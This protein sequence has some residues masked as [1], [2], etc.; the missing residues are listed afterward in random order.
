MKIDYIKRI[1]NDGPVY[2]LKV[3]GCHNYYANNILVSNCHLAK[4]RSIQKISYL[5]KNADYRLGFTGTLPEEKADLLN[6]QSGLGPQICNVKSEDLID[7]GI[8]SKI[9]V[10]NL[11]LKYPKE[12]VD[13]GKKFDYLGEIDLILENQRRNGIFKWI[14]SNVKSGENTLI[15]C[16]LIDKHLRVIEKYLRENLDEKYQ[17]HIIYGGT[18]VTEREKIKKILEANENVIV[19]ASYGT[20]STGLNLKKLHNVIFAS[21]YK[22]KIKVLQ[23]IGR[24]LRLHLEKSKLIVWDIVDD[25]TYFR[26]ISRGPRKGQIEKVKNHVFKHFE[27]RLQYYNDQG[28]PFVS[29]EFALSELSKGV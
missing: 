13:R 2:N 11:I 27:E 7:Q 20:C 18:A 12:L 29:K 17:I 3:S 23:S 26:K 4:A 21:S 8:L 6:I 25:L 19:L 14:F 10:A 24:G 5:C 9:K 16:A 28:F 1:N 15:L 22:S